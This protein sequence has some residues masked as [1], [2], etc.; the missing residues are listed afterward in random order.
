[1]FGSSISPVSGNW[2]MVAAP[3][4]SLTSWPFAASMAD[5]TR[6]RELGAAGTYP[7]GLALAVTVLFTL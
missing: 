7:F 2:R 6:A 4:A 3:S 1:M 5:V